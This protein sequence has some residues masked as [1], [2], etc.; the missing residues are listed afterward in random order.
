MN[1]PHLADDAATPWPAWHYLFRMIR[2]RPWL[3][4]LNGTLWVLI[5]VAPLLPGLLTLAFF[6]ALTGA[7]EIAGGVQAIVILL[8]VIGVVRV[9][10]MLGGALADILHRFIMASLLRRNLL[11]RILA[12]PGAQPS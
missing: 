1:A 9:L 2:Y 7:G 10:L 3:Y 6:N 8:V 11:T 12:R 5:H 4:L